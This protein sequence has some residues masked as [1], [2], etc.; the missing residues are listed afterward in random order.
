VTDYSIREYKLVKSMIKKFPKGLSRKELIKIFEEKNALIG[1]APRK[2]KFPGRDKIISIVDAGNGKHW[3]YQKGGGQSKKS[4][5]ISIELDIFED[6]TPTLKYIEFEFHLKKLDELW[7]KRKKKFSLT[8][9]LEFV[10][11]RDLIIGFPIS[12]YYGKHKHATKQEDLFEKLVEFSLTMLE[13]IN[14][15]EAAQNKYD[16]KF[17]IKIK[18]VDVLS[19]IL[20][21]EKTLSPETFKNKEHLKSI[22]RLQTLYRIKKYTVRN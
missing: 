3:N 16:K 2:V 22:N 11:I 15:I 1:N 7:T 9:M 20:L 13:K 17:K 5:I 19:D 21:L 18:N 12:I 4:N 14:K 6:F 8:E 10:K